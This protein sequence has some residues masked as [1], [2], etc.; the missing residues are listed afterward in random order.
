MV[1]VLTTVALVLV[2]QT[3]DG[4]AAARAQYEA[5][6]VEAALNAAQAVVENDPARP[7]ACLE[8]EALALLVLGR[9]EEARAV[10]TEMFE[11]D[12]RRP[13]EDKSLAPSVQRFIEEIREQLLPLRAR[14]AARWIVHESLRL[15]VALDGG[16]RGADEVRYDAHFGPEGGFTSGRIQLAGRAATATVTVPSMDVR[17]VRV[18][19]RVVD[20]LGREVHQFSSELL[21]PTRPNAKG[22]VVEVDSGPAWWVWA[23]VGTAVVGSAVAVAFVAQPDLPSADGTLGRAEAPP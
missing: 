22:V 6:D 8:V 1:G 23:L 5:L 15:D 11:R 2:G 12:P 9:R 16:L 14:V 21:L 20:R 17:T 13:I 18:D 7:L 19:G 4:C 10:L 3:P